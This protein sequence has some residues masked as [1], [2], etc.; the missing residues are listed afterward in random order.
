MAS[1]TV[2]V[3]ELAVLQA[4]AGLDELPVALQVPLGSD[5]A[6][7]REV[8]LERGL[9]TE[10]G[11]S[12]SVLPLLRVLADPEASVS[13][14]ASMMG[15]RPVMRRG[16]VA[17]RGGQIVGAAR[18]DDAVRLG[19]IEGSVAG[20]LRDIVGPAPRGR[21]LSARDAV[22]RH[23]A[24]ALAVDGARDANA[25]IIGLRQ[26]GV[27]ADDAFQFGQVLHHAE[28]VVEVTA[29]GRA[30]VAVID[31]QHG[32]VLV[33]PL[34]E[35]DGAHQRVTVC[36]GSDHRLQRALEQAWRPNARSSH[37]IADRGGVRA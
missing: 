17:R 18:S 3:A 13:A 30:P 10:R 7:A 5:D 21:E 23:D 35:R 9:L 25:V 36:A 33:L 32:R 6:A 27:A 28:R 37:R 26:A 22:V 20:F 4:A 16:V 15:A 8:L 24:L 2:S 11:P 14:R 12:T 34:E 1:L 19:P 29:P 31:A